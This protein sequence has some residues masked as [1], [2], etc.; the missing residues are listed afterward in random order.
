M[1]VLSLFSSSVMMPELS[2]ML[3]RPPG[4]YSL[5]TTLRMYRELAEGRGRGEGT[6]GAGAYAVHPAGWQV[7]F[8][9]WSFL[10]ASAPCRSQRGP[11]MPWRGKQTLSG[12][13]GFAPQIKC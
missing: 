4:L 7:R 13:T 8:N 12:L 1:L 2:N 6:P 3:I 10:K 9:S 5:V 11:G